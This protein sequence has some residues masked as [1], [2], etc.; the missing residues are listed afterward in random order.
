MYPG[1]WI[2]ISFNVFSEW[3]TRVYFLDPTTATKKIKGKTRKKNRFT[4]ISWKRQN[5]L[6][7]AFAICITEQ[8]KSEIIAAP[9]FSVAMDGNF[10][11]SKHEQLVFVTRFS[12]QK[13]GSVNGRLMGVRSSS[14]ATDE[15][16]FY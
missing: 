16:L 13:T 4:Y 12:D 2:N 7:E 5:Q 3:L 8:A 6:I 14:T 9:F 10:G 1:N 15:Q 11:K